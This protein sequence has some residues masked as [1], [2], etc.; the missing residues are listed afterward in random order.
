METTP[1]WLELPLAG[2]SFHGPK[3]VQAI[4]V[5]LCQGNI[6]DYCMVILVFNNTYL[7]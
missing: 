6:P 5:L 3:R 2:T 4:E 1:G 7:K